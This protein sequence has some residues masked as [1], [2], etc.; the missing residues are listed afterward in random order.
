MRGCLVFLASIIVVAAIVLGP[1]CTIWAV[2]TLFGLSIPYTLETWAAAL[3]IGG[4][5]GGSSYASSSKK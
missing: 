2:N 4:V 3:W 5:V 1:I